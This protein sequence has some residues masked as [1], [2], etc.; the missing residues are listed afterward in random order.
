[1]DI[2]HSEGAVI[3]VPDELYGEEVMAFVVSKDKRIKEKDVLESCMKS[4][5]SYKCPKSI[6]FIDE[7]SKN[8]IGKIQK[9]EPRKLV[10]LRK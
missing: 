4:M 7:I 8:S 6:E 9:N 2:G 5:A 3:G 10:S 1:M